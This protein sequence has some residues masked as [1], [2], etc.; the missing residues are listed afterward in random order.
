MDEAAK[1]PRQPK[2]FAAGA[3]QAAVS[4]FRPNLAAEGKS[5]K[6]VRVYT[7]AVQWFAAAHLLRET[8]RTSWDEVC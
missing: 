6:T 4:S 3:F 7:E 8:T 1:R 2:P 5:C